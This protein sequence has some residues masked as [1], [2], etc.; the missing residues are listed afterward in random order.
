[1]SW[2]KL[3]L[4]RPIF[5]EKYSIF[6]LIFPLYIFGNTYLKNAQFNFFYQYMLLLTE[7]KQPSN[8]IKIKKIGVTLFAVIP[9]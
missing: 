5:N 4:L 1:M 6:S 9:L 7:V 3:G 8:F 2:Q